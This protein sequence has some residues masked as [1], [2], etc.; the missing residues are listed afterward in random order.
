MK[1]VKV[2]NDVDEVQFHPELGE[3]VP[4]QEMEVPDELAGLSCFT[5]IRSAK[6]D[7]EKGVDE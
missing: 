2:N 5:P 3:L 1:R 6:K 7:K 4:G